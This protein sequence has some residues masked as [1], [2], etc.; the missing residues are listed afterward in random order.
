MNKTPASPPAELPPD[1]TVRRDSTG[2]IIEILY[3]KDK[4]YSVYEVAA[5]VKEL[6]EQFNFLEKSYKGKS[7]PAMQKIFYEE[8]KMVQGWIKELNQIYYYF[9]SNKR[10]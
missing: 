6:V 4:F 2:K 3:K 5:R 7:N 9:K 8:M 10:S 1:A